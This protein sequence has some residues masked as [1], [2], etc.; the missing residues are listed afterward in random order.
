MTSIENNVAEN[1]TK[2]AKTKLDVKVRAWLATILST[3]IG[4]NRG[5]S[6]RYY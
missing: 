2:K 3:V 6:T 5:E 4:T 1:S